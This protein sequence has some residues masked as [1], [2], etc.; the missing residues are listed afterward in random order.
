[1]DKHTPLSSNTLNILKH[2]N[3]DLIY[4]EPDVKKMFKEQGITIPSQ[5]RDLAPFEGVV[6][7][8]SN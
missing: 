4:V 1:M 7:G 6:L 2:R 3:I 8:G 5:L